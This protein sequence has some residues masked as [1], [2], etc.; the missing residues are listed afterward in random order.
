MPNL[1]DYENVGKILVVTFKANA[2][3][4]H[5]YFKMHNYFGHVA[6][7]QANMQGVPA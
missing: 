2:W 5:I 4:T 6:H 7:L 3:G 1:D